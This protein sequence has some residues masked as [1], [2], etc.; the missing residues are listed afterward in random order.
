MTEETAVINVPILHNVWLNI[1]VSMFK[2]NWWINTISASPKMLSLNLEHTH[3]NFETTNALYILIV[4]SLVVFLFPF[5]VVGCRNCYSWIKTSS[6]VNEWARMAHFKW[7]N[8]DSWKKQGF[9][10]FNATLYR[11]DVHPVHSIIYLLVLGV[12]GSESIWPLAS[13]KYWDL[14]HI[15][16]YLQS[17]CILLLCGGYTQ[18][19][20]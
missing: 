4:Y 5:F 20:L 16:F 11:G 9:F 17:L 19:P 18:V 1:V 15:W 13:F 14:E 3:V 7:V 10:P 2:L 12:Q 8:F 6:T